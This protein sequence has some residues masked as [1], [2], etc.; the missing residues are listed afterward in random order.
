MLNIL[1]GIGIGGAM[2]MIQKANKKHRQDPSHPIKYKPYRIQVG[3][4]LMISAITLLVMLVGLLI[5]V[6]MNK[7]ILSRKIGWG[8]IALWAVSTIVNV[9]VELTGVWGEM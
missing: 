6:P 5:V 3:G 8:L 1:L 7:W 2:M 4:T 9:V